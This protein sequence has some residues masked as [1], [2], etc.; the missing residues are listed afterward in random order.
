[1][2]VALAAV[3]LIWGSTYLAIRYAIETIPPLLMAAARFIIAGGVMY[4]WARWK[5]SG[6]P[7]GKH[8]RAAVIIGC[9][10]FLGGNGAVVWAEQIVPS[11]LTALLVST[12]PLWMVLLDS[13]HR[14]GHKL[15]RRNIAG[16][17]LGFT[18]VGL[19][20]APGSILGHGHVD[21]RGA[22]VLLIGSLAW[23]TG[24]LYSR[25]AQLPNS[26]IM[27]SGIEMLAGG[28]CLIV[29]GLVSGE[30]SNFAMKHVTF[31]SLASLLYLVAF[32]SII[33]FT[34]YAWLL[35][36][37]T[38]ARAA[39]YAYVN[40]LVAMFIGWAIGGEPLTSRTIMAAVVIISAVVVIIG[41]LNGRKQVPHPA[42]SGGERVQP[43]PV[44][45]TA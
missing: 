1:M 26:L 43:P 20:I 31:L 29:A 2:I 39:T 3:Y 35:A 27:A 40:P 36:H 38:P 16:L 42:D 19:L 18:G 5:G 34:A 33:G 21:L 41:R 37:T 12:V 6:P 28:A 30:T 7:T 25:R 14:H 13:L 17:V 11:G 9:L 44:K 24:S 15:T 23:S 32:G 8:W 10:L 45:P 22:G 4:T